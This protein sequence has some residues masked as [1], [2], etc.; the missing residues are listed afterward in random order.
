MV[1]IGSALPSGM[2]SVW[3]LGSARGRR[4][5]LTNIPNECIDGS[6]HGVM[7]GIFKKNQSKG[8]PRISFYVWCGKNT[9]M[10]FP[11]FEGFN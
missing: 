7:T 3:R 5:S 1:W 6:N 11:K 2:R 10:I 4:R 8:T 9:G